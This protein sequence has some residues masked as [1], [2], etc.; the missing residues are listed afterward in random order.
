M[1]D[2]DPLNQKLMKGILQKGRYSILTAS[3]GREALHTCQKFDIDLVLLDIMMPEMDGFETCRRLK[4]QEHTRLIPIIL[5]TALNDSQSKLR[6]IEVGA[7]DFISRPPNHP[8]LL[9][10]T[11]SL[12]NVKRLNKSLTSVEN[13]LF[14]MARAVEA[15]D[16]YTQGHI[17]RV[18]NLAVSIGRNM[19][20]KAN[21][22]KAL[23]YGGILHDMGKIGIPH[24]ILNK[25]GPLTDQE[26]IVMKQHPEIGYKI[27]MPLGDT[28]GSALD[29]I[30]YH[31]E[32]MDGSGYPYGLKDQE[33]PTV[34]RIMAVA[35][36]YDALVTDRPYR[37]GMDRDKSI[38]IL[39]AETDEGKLDMTVT[40][41][42][43]E[44]ITSGTSLEPPIKD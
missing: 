24:D 35:D 2:D 14:S 20:L 33:I 29:V 42:L 19:E 25:P 6:G 15:K 5:L 8:E 23:H 34:A 40:K 16:K 39:T 44:M 7:D 17:E 12:I 26:W 27:C 13:V 10:R 36:I 22:M 11:H 3:N 31:H 37:K 43:I 4:K 41:I 38:N 1:V 28:L 21:E 32:K 9:A 18:A 30:R